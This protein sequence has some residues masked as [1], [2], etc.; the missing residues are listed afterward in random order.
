M[1][2]T[3]NHKF[4]KALGQLH[5]PWY[6]QPLI[7]IVITCRIHGTIYIIYVQNLGRVKMLVVQGSPALTVVETRAFSHVQGREEVLEGVWG[8]K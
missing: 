3:T 4:Y 1:G 7:E 6:K 8:V 5:D 2:S